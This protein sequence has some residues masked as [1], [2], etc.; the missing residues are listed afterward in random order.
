VDT[1]HDIILKP[2]L[3]RFCVCFCIEESAPLFTNDQEWHCLVSSAV[4]KKTAGFPGFYVFTHLG[5]AED[6][7]ITNNAEGKPKENPAAPWV[8]L[9]TAGI[10]VY[11][12]LIFRIT[13]M[14]NAISSNYK[15][16]K[17]QLSSKQ[18]GE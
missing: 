15:K 13:A 6:P 2:D 16:Q 9:V 12:L 17:Q 11:C 8:F 5:S 4:T 7:V 1:V 10:H 14:R 18:V 3:S